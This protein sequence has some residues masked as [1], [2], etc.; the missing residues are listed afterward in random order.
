MRDSRAR[1]GFTGSERVSDRD[2]GAR[3]RVCACMCL[4]PIETRIVGN[5]ER[6]GSIATTLLFF[7][8]GFFLLSFL[9]L[10]PVP[11]CFCVVVVAAVVN[12]LRVVLFLVLSTRNS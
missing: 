12:C 1:V 8:S 10:F 3:P 11:L 9:S 4:G 7:F 6:A 2:R 5:I